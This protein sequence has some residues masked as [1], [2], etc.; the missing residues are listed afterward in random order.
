MKP[1]SSDMCPNK[2]DLATD[3]QRR[4]NFVNTHSDT[5]G[6]NRRRS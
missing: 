1:H 2:E 4:E 3:F 5:K 6:D